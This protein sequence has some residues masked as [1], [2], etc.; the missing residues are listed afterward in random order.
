[1]KH[2]IIICTICAFTLSSC[3]IFK[4]YTPQQQPKQDTFISS[5]SEADWQTYITDPVLR[6]HINTALANNVDIRSRKLAIEQADARLRAAKL[7]F[8]PTLAIS[9]ANV[10]VSGTVTPGSGASGATLSYQV[11]LA[12]NWGGEGLGTLTNRKRQAACLRDQA[13]DNLAAEHANLVATIARAYT[14]LQMLDYQA[15]I[16]DSTELL[17]QRV[18]ETQ[19]I[20]VKNGK[21]YSPSV[22]QMETSLINVQIQREQLKQQTYQLELAI[23]LLMNEE[24]HVIARSAWHTEAEDISEKSVFA[25]PNSLFPIPASQLSNR[26]D[27]RA[28][29]RNVAAAFYQ[30]NMAKAA[31]CPAL[32]L[33]GLIGW[34]NNGG[35]VANPGQLLMNAVL[36][37]A[38]PIFTGGKLKANLTIAK[39]EQEEAA[40]RYVQ[41]MLRAGNEVNDAIFRCKSSQER[42]VLYR[43]MLEVQ[44]EAYD[45]TRELMNKGKASYIEVLTA[46]EA[47]L[48]AQLADATNRYNA[49]ISLIDLYI[50]LGGGTK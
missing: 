3:A 40:N 14:Q 33:S 41:T 43:R 4:K 6:G 10:G 49:I 29:E 9:T 47:Y 2:S 1:M 18:L 17:W 46:Q 23:C 24:P 37:L 20:L 31:F 34:T 45:G 30:T 16:I 35:I 26:A 44:K 8:L 5:V 50:A 38:Q 15:A 19:R 32:S 36:G 28:A 11:P 39:L 7:G 48:N 27:V 13:E 42:D 12:L 25:T 22:G 21:A